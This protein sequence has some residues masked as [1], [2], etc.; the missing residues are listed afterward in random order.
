MIA[1][2]QHFYENGTTEGLMDLDPG[3]LTNGFIVRLC[4]VVGFLQLTQADGVI[5]DKE[6]NSLK[7]ATPELQSFE[8]RR[9]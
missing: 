7:A 8:D 6:A 3:D 9:K 5:S 2:V 1:E 4:D